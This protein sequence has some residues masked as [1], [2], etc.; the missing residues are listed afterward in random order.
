MTTKIRMITLLTIVSLFF[1]TAHLSPKTFDGEL[2]LNLGFPQND[3]KNNVDRIFLGGGFSFAVRLGKSPFKLGLDTAILNYGHNKRYET[4]VN[5]PDLELK[6]VNSYNILQFLVFLRY[7]IPG[8]KN[9]HLYLEGLTGFN[10]LW[11][12]TSLKN[13]Q[14]YDEI[15]GSINLDDTA[16]AWGGGA[17]ALIKLAT[18]YD[19]KNRKNPI[20]NI[21]ININTRYIFSSK[22]E[23]M[24][25]DS[26]LIE[27][28]E[29]TYLIYESKTDLLTSHLG[30]VVTF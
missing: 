29:L 14:N 19:Q 27:N 10:Y 2:Y 18:I 6:V 7:E 3:F 1:F 17:G 9:F 8:S 20:L 30:I 24:K 11:T 13:H 21:Y 12:G 16:F 26:I 5:I 25:K 23:Y 22:A 28:D 4:L 15:I